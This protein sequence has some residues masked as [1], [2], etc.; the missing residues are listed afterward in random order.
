MVFVPLLMEINYRFS[1]DDLEGDL[2]LNVNRVDI[3]N[4][5]FIYNRLNLKY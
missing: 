4:G 3:S 5:I 2:I 1:M